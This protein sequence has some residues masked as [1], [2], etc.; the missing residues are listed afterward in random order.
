MF[1]RGIPKE[2]PE[3]IRDGEKG[4]QGVDR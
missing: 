4:I 1:S 2:N 3:I